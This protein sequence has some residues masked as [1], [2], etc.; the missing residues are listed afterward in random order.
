[1]TVAN[2]LAVW[3]VIIFTVI[4]LQSVQ[5]AVVIDHDSSWTN[6]W[7]ANELNSVDNVQPERNFKSLFEEFIRKRKQ[8]IHDE[9]EQSF[10]HDIKL[11]KNEQLANQVIMTAK[12]D[13]LRAGFF[14]PHRF[15]PSRHIFDTLHDIKQSKLFHMLKI[16]PKGGILHIHELAMC[17]TNFLVSL[18]YWPDLWL[19][20]PSNHSARFEIFEFRFL[21]E[22]PTNQN[23]QI[24]RD[25]T[26]TNASIDGNDSMW[27]LVKDVRTEMGASVFDE[28]VRS[29]FT[30]YDT[31]VNTT[32]Q[33]QDIND[34]WDR[35]RGR[36]INIRGILA[37]AP[38]RR[39]YFK[40]ALKEFYDD[41]VQ[42]VEIRTRIP[43]VGRNNFF[44]YFSSIF[45]YIIC[46]LSAIE[47]SRFRWKLLY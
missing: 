6:Q 35:F 9:T 18:T 3:Y 30:L 40:Q 39:V 20:T 21:R 36:F 42:Y 15:N 28:H 31:N 11:N 32:T 23:K 46:L 25:S 1:M 13:E 16:M 45:C 22:Q 37:Y 8:L 43:K 19:R 38:I 33:F 4:E 29:M 24:A 5:L 27:R 12:R 14:E 41:G 17:S 44:Y 26:D 10:G 34:V 2:S 7:F 47:A